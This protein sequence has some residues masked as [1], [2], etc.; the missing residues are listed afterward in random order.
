MAFSPDGSRLASGGGETFAH[1]SQILFWDVAACR[2]LGSID[3]PDGGIRSLALSPNGRA[4]TAA[5]GK[6]ARTWDVETGAAGVTF[7]GHQKLVER[8]AY[9]T[10]GSVAGDW[11]H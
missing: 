6:L 11:K 10:D 4:I 7:A 8:I 9:T 5:A 2:P 3:C 1:D